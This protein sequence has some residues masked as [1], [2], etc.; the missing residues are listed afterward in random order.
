MLSILEKRNIRNLIHFTRAEN[1][2]GIIENGL[3][4]RDCLDADTCIFNDE[5]RYDQCED[6]VCTSIEFPNYK[7]FFSLR[8]AHPNTDWVVLILDSS[9]LLD[10]ECAFCETNAGSEAMY[11]TP[12]ENRMGPHAFEKLF[13]PTSAGKNRA[14]LFIPDHYPTNPQ[15]EVLVFGCIPI[16]YIKCIAFDSHLTKA[17]YSPIIA[18][19]ITAIVDRDLFYGRKDYRHWQVNA[20]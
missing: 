6:A 10:F 1:L 4:P 19:R 11:E 9:I 13:C 2:L 3:L 5:Y 12:L 15:A 7:M 16:R 14:D 20:E 8:S 17:K 18:N